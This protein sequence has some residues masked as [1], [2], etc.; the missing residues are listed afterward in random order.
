VEFETIDHLLMRILRSPQD[1]VP[2]LE[3]VDKTRIAL[4]DRGGE[5]DDAAQNILER[6]RGRHAAADFV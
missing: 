1:Q 3:D 6:F 5:I 2:I 4:H